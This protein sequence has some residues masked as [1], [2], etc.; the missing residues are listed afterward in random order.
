MATSDLQIRCRRLRNAK[1]AVWYTNLIDI[2]QQLDSDVQRHLLQS[3]LNDVIQLLI[4]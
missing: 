3:P 1:I 2:V 4:S